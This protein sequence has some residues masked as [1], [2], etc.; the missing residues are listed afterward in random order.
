MVNKNP[1]QQNNDNKF[2]NFANN[3]NDDYHDRENKKYALLKA[4]YL[5]LLAEFENKVG[6]R[7][8]GGS[9]AVG[10]G[11][12]FATGMFS[13]DNFGNEAFEIN[14]FIY[15]LMKNLEGKGISTEDIEHVI[16]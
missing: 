15:I 4:K 11:K 13:A 9:Q 1:V 2:S 16:E 5:E 14:Q 8:V 3:F 10:S 12:S 6:E 7:S